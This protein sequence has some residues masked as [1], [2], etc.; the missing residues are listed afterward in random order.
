MKYLKNALMADRRAS[1][2]KKRVSSLQEPPKD[3]ISAR[4][5]AFSRRWQCNDV[6]FVY[7]VKKGAITQRV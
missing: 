2:E 7:S 6:Q 1:G 4:K 5:P 3:S